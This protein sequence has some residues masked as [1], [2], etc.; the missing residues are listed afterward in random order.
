MEYG[1]LELDEARNDFS[2]NHL[3]IWFAGFGVRRTVS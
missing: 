1:V 2:G 3:G